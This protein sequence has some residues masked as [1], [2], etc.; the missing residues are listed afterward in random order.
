[1]SDNLCVCCGEIIP[2][3]K[4]VCPSCEGKVTKCKH[5]KKCAFVKAFGY[6]IKQI[7]EE[8]TFK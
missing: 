6:C 3:G 4:Q 1:M 7:G 5:R 8:C 2:E